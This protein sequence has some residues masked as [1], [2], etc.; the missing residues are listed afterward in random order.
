MLND[1]PS[2]RRLIF[3]LLLTHR[4]IYDL[5]DLLDKLSVLHRDRIHGTH[6]AVT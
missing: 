1:L 3:F 5:D 6:M 2:F 4:D